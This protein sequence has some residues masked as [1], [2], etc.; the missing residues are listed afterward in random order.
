MEQHEN[1]PRSLDWVTS[2]DDPVVSAAERTQRSR[3]AT[4][5][6]GLLFGGGA[7]AAVAFLVTALTRPAV[8]ESGLGAATSAPP[9]SPVPTV[10]QSASAEPSLIPAG[11]DQLFSENMAA[12][13]QGVGLELG[14]DWDG[15]WSSGSADAELQ[16]LL[17]DAALDCHWSQDDPE[18]VAL[19]TQV[20]EVT[21]H[22]TEIATARLAELGFN[23]LSEH[24]GVRYVLEQRTGDAL[25]GESH[26]FREGLWFATHWRGHGQ[27]G[28]TADMVQS[29]FG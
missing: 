4:L 16:Q 13:L 5:G 20:S 29:V 1:E 18:G 28:Y 10:T 11:C 3:V 21:N 9:T 25:S 23:Q 24:G 6:L 15:P 19:L 17:D 14:E 8:E 12:T 22:E 27:F 7:I 26:F 2:F